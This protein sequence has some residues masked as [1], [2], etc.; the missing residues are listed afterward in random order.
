M[1]E[2]GGEPSGSPPPQPPSLQSGSRVR[3]VLE[4]REREGGRNEDAK[5]L[6]VFSAVRPRLAL[7]ATRVTPAPVT[8]NPP[9]LIKAPL[10]PL[11]HPPRV[12]LNH[13][14]G[15]F[16]GGSCWKN[17]GIFCSESAVNFL[18]FFS[19]KLQRVKSDFTYDEW[20]S[21]IGQSLTYGT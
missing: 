18:C 6:S 10:P 12:I 7:S 16:A 4:V 21:L 1:P 14:L 19:L 13:W 20:L 3:N 2:N 11:P 15:G 9:L 5:W 17:L 8:M